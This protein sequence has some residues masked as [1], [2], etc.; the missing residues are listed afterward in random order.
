MKYTILLLPGAGLSTVHQEKILADTLKAALGEE[1]SIICPKMPDAD[2]PSY[3]NWVNVLIE[4]LKTTRGKII[5]VGHSLGGSVIL[6]HFSMAPVP[7]CIIGM[8]L[9][10][11]PFWKYQD[12][13]VSEFVIADKFLPNFARL[14]N[15]YFYYSKDDE[16]IPFDHYGYY[17]E[18][19]PQS[20][21][22]L[23]SN[24]DHSYH[25][26]IPNIIEDI[27]ALVKNATQ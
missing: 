10:G 26:A 13:D 5:L 17:Q 2:N 9:L 1:F 16:V 6:K 25:N 21:K 15:I 18:L 24:V 7:S 8:V 12:W 20:H 4:H 14:D 11:V 22:R 23:L 27:Q 3:E 19:M